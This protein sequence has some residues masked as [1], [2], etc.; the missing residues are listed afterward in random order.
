M[1]FLLPKL[2]GLIHRSAGIKDLATKQAVQAIEAWADQLTNRLAKM[3]GGAADVDLSGYSPVGHDHDNFTDTTDGYVPAPNNGGLGYCLLDDGTWG[4]PVSGA[5]A[6]ILGTGYDGPLNFDGSSTVL[7]ISPSSSSAYSLSGSSENVYI[8]TRSINPT[9]MTVAS[10]VRVVANGYAIVGTGTLTLNGIVSNNGRH[11]TGSITGAAGGGAGDLPG[12]SPGTDG[13]VVGN[14]APGA[15]D[16]TA[17]RAPAWV[18]TASGAA[19]GNGTTGTNGTVGGSGRG[20]GGG[21]RRSG[22]GIGAIDGAVGGSSTLS[23]TSGSALLPI[24]GLLTGMTNNTSPLKYSGGSGGGGGSADGHSLGNGPGGGG[25][26][27]WVVLL[28]SSFSGSGTVESRG[29]KGGDASNVTATDARPGGGGGGGGGGTI[30]L[31]C[32]AGAFP[33]TVT[34]GGAGGA[35]GTGTGT[36]ALNGTN[37]GAGGNGRTFQLSLSSGAGG[38]GGSGLPDGDYG[39]ISVSGGTTALTIDAGAVTA[40]KLASDAVTTA[41]IA[42]SNVTTAKIADSNVTTAKVADNAIT[43]AKIEDTAGARLMGALSATSPSYLTGTQ[44]TT[45]LD[46]ATASDKG[47]VPASGGGTTNYLRA[48]MTWAAPS[49]GGG[50][51]VKAVSVYNSTTQSISNATNTAITYN[52]EIFDTDS[53]HSTSI[54]TSRLTAPSTGY[55]LVTACAEFATSSSGMRYLKI[56]KNGTTEYAL[57]NAK[58]VSTYSGAMS[59]SAI[60]HL[61]ASTDYVEAVVYQDSGGALNILG[62]AYN[63]F[64]MIFIGA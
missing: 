56:R 40:S 35:G 13:A 51:A 62:A 21:A 49:G 11:N 25:G 47:L 38:G 16:N 37:G 23:T 46:V 24:Y 45:L 22:P 27:G 55:Y 34:A 64:S 43:M 41:K 63:P 20:G 4:S 6:L 58:G 7:G 8:L 31:G 59:C 39:D 19:G 53:F 57:V 48:D 61:T 50:S 32:F 3:E 5:P 36:G 18:G 30:V 26:G 54:N 10:G 12:G 15:G 33:S 9:N 2:K 44:A 28:F 42:D 29:G 14:N 60:V 52:S 1:A 17:P